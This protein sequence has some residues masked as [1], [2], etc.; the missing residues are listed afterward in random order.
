[1]GSEAV[2]ISEAIDILES[3]LINIARVNEWADVMGY[4]N[5]KVF[6]TKFHRH[7]EVRPQKVLE[8]V[9]L[10]SVVKQLKRNNTSNF[11]VALAHGIPDEIALNKFI[12]YHL[13]C[14]PTDIKYMSDE[15]LQSKMESFGSKVSK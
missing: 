3:N 6:S 7:Y 14:S 13:G 4:K 1:M 5:P 11:E 9:R 10:N 2:R 15:Q 12:N 8:F